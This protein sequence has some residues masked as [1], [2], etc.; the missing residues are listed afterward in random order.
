MA[1][2]FTPIVKTRDVNTGIDGMEL[3]PV[4]KRYYENRISMFGTEAWHDL[5]DD[6]RTMESSTN[7][8]SAIQDEKTLHFRRGELS[9]MRWLLG[10]E[11]MSRAA[12]DQ[13]KAEK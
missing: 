13:L 11:E 10:L 1:D 12:F 9:I 2:I 4:L 6:I 7:D 5:I 8:I 3:D